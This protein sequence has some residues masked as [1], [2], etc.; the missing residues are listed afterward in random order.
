MYRHNAEFL[1]V[2]AGAT[3]SSQCAITSSVTWPRRIDRVNGWKINIYYKK[4]RKIMKLYFHMSLVISDSQEFHDTVPT[5][6]FMYSWTS[7]PKRLHHTL[8]RQPCG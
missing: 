8:C 2:I 3:Y 5:A 6:E 1:N 4:Y 7:E